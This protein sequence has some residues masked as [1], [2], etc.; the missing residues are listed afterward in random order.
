MP[1]DRIACLIRRLCQHGDLGHQSVEAIHALPWRLIKRLKHSYVLRDGDQ[2]GEISVLISGF[3]QRL[4]TTSEGTRQIVAFSLAG[5]P[6]DFECLFLDEADFSVQL[7]NNATIACVRKDA[8]RTLLETSPEAARAVMAA[9]L[10]DAAISRE[11]VMNVGRRDARQRIA[12]LLCEVIVRLRAQDI[13][14]EP[15]EVPF[16]QEQLAD[17]TG[18]TPVHVNRVLKQLSTEGAIRRSGRLINIPNWE[19]LEDI[20]DFDER[21]LHMDLATRPAA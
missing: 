15:F 8:V 16:T 10:A 3:A 6:L 21:F 4:K 1:N 12:H 18:L 2:P 5:D 19:R 7:C 13:K 20:A 11:W 14:T 9:L 17:A